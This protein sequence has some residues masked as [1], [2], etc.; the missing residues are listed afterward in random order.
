MKRKKP[1]TYRKKFA[2]FLKY[3][4]L[5]NQKLVW[6]L[7]SVSSWQLLDKNDSGDGNGFRICADTFKGAM[8]KFSATI[9]DLSL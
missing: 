5:Q 3:L 4:I 2:W 7:P 1:Q 6:R 8:G 9:H